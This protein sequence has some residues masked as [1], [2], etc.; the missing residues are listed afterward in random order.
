MIQNFHIC[1][2]IHPLFKFISPILTTKALLIISMRCHNRHNVNSYKVWSCKCSCWHEIYDAIISLHL[3][4]WVFDNEIWFLTK[5]IWVPGPDRIKNYGA[6][7]YVLNGF[8]FY[9][10]FLF[11]FLFLIEDH[12]EMTLNSKSLIIFWEK[13]SWKL[14]TF[15][16]F[17]EWFFKC[18]CWLDH[19]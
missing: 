1:F 5:Q 13:K 10:L 6:S 12:N 16:T 15:T 18:C 14:F 8:Y 17:S 19:L 11:L 2:G 7:I 9:F 3:F 4:H